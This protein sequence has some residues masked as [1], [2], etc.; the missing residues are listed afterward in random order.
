MK[1]FRRYLL[2]KILRN[3]RVYEFYLFAIIKARSIKHK[4]ER[5][6]AKI[7]PPKYLSIHPNIL[8]LSIDSLRPDHLGCY[9]YHRNTSPNIDKLAKNSAIFTN[10]IC[11]AP[12][13][14]PSIGSLFTAVNPGVHGADKGGKFGQDIAR[15]SSRTDAIG[16]RDMIPTLTEK[17]KE[18][19]YITAGFTGGGYTHSIFGLDRGFDIYK[20]NLSLMD[21]INFE[22]FSFLNRD[23]KK[24]IFLFIHTFDVHFPYHNKKPYN[25]LFGKFDSRINMSKQLSLDINYGRFTPSDEDIQHMITLYDGSIF[26]I[27]QRIGF[28]LEMLQTLGF[29]Q[30]VMIILTADHGEGFMEHDLVGHSEI[31]YNEVL[32]IP[33]IIYHSNMTSKRVVSNLV[34]SID[35]MPTLLE[36]ANIPCDNFIQGKG[37]LPLLEK[38]ASYDEAAFSETERL[39]GIQAIQTQEGYKFVYWKKTEKKELYDLNNDPLERKNIIQLMPEKAEELEHKLFEIIRESEDLSKR[40]EAMKKDKTSERKEI[41]EEDIEA[42]TARLRALGYID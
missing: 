31:I 42:V 14:K 25:R 40:I 22:V 37:L 2:R 39:G 32:R 1:R 18:G 17:L 34:R 24:P 27:D 21:L 9:G 8:L 6:K 19:D 16:L 3:K 38:E 35:L 26:Y 13:T 5:I 7:F 20:A 10:A 29:M 12:W 28:L 23:F 33:L 36:F 4:I 15:I 11:Q 41:S 30:N